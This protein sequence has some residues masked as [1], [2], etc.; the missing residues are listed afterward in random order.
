MDR[1]PN[2]FYGRFEAVDKTGLLANLPGG[3]AD[4]RIIRPIQALTFGFIHDLRREPLVVG[5]GA[6][7]T[8]YAQ[9]G[10][11][12]AAYGTTPMAFRVFLRVRPPLMAHHPSP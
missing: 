6:D 9:P 7:A 4:E 11:L 2:H 3:E 12:S 8:L 1:G 5:I 10:D